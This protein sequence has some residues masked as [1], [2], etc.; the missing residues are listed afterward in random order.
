MRRGD[1]RVRQ[2]LVDPADVA[3]DVVH[4]VDV[5][6]QLVR[7]CAHLGISVDAHHTRIRVHFVNDVVCVVHRRQASA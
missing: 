5:G 6:D 3:G 1:N 2:H 4:V 7:V